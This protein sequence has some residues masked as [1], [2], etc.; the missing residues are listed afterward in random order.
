MRYTLNQ[1]PLEGYQGLQLSFYTDNHQPLTWQNVLQGWLQDPEFQAYFS[2]ALETVPYP[3]YFWETPPL[4]QTRQH[5]P[6][7]CVV[8]NSPALAQVQ[9]DYSPFA[10]YVR[11][12]PQQAD[13]RVFSNLGGDAQLISP[14]PVGEKPTYPHLAAFLSNAPQG[15]K[16]QLWATLAQTIM[17]QL[18]HQPLRPFWVSTSGLGVFWLH[19]RL[20]WQ[21][22]YYQYAPY[23]QGA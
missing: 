17:E 5:Q 8:I 20:D 23:R 10:Q 7:T 13:V 16:A 15:L 6:F 11:P 2:T 9:A 12:S 4:N 19:L 3:A 14:C 18:Q 1:I 22:K 21:P